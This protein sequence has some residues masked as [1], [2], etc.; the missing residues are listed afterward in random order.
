MKP[1][2]RAAVKGFVLD[3][4]QLL[5][6]PGMKLLLELA[7]IAGVAMWVLI[8]ALLWKDGFD[9]LFERFTRPRWSTAQRLGT[10]VMIP[11]RAIMLT[12]AAALGGTVTTLGLL[13]NIAVILNLL[14]ASEMLFAG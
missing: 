6:A 13:I 5:A 9:D 7:P 1:I 14:R 4:D 11:G 3:I 10:V 12:L 8:T 2:R